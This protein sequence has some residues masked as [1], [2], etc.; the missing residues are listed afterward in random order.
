MFFLSFFFLLYFKYILWSINKI[1]YYFYYI[2]YIYILNNIKHV[3]YLDIFRSVC[4]FRAVDRETR[5]CGLYIDGPNNLSLPPPQQNK[6]WRE[7]NKGH[8][9]HFYRLR[10]SEL[11]ASAAHK[12]N[13]PAPWKCPMSYSLFYPFLIPISPGLSTLRSRTFQQ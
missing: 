12:I 10:F 4:T 8:Y 5:A 3:M 2:L 13:F 9:L 1:K 11:S 6:I 7:K